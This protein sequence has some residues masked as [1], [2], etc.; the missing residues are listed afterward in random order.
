MKAL[1][2]EDH[3]LDQLLASGPCTFAD[4]LAYVREQY[5]GQAQ[6]YELAYILTRLIREGLVARCRHDYRRHHDA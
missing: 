4:I 3:V 1:N 6:D 2:L 5:S